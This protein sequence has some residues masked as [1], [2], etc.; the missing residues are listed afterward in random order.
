M[1]QEIELQ[2]THIPY[3][4]KGNIQFYVNHLGFHAAEFTYERNRPKQS[5][6]EFRDPEGISNSKDKNRNICFY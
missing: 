1:N 2:I 5:E 4:E 3:F 6:N